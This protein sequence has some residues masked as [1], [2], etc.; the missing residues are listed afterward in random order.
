MKIFVNKKRGP[1]DLSHS[2][3]KK[4]IKY[5]YY[6]YNDFRIIVYTIYYYL[7]ILV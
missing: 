4:L 1:E 3:L 2:I 6:S 7:Q 5:I